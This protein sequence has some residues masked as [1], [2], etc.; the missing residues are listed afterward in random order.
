MNC[1][2]KSFK[3]C[4]PI[5]YLFFILFLKYQ[6]LPPP[7]RNVNFPILLKYDSTLCSQV[8]WKTDRPTHPI[9]HPPCTNAS[10]IFFMKLQWPQ[11][12]LSWPLFCSSGT[13]FCVPLC[14]DLG[15]G[16]S[17]F[18]WHMFTYYGGAVNQ[19]CSSGNCNK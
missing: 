18:A 8:C 15:H 4:I 13:E 14:P 19:G 17:G 12:I 7:H 1:T 5:F 6:L 9:L 10:L 16:P 3:K 2:V 11:A